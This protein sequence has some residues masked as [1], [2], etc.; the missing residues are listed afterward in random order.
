ML[1]GRR[2]RPAAAGRH[3]PSAATRDHPD[4]TATLEVGGADNDGGVRGRSGSGRAVAVAPRG[5]AGWCVAAV[6]QHGDDRREPAAAHALPL[7]P[8]L[9]GGGVQ[10]GGAPGVGPAAAVAGPARMH[11]I[12]GANENCIALHASD[13][14]VAL[15]ALDAVVHIRGVDGAADRSADRV[16]CAPG[17]SSGRR[18][19]CSSMGS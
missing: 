19:T 15:V 14:C 4:A 8:R 11:A 1:K 12:L 2:G 17:R 3:H 5:V 18:E 9:D 16:L 6:A 10:Q 13:L 7:F